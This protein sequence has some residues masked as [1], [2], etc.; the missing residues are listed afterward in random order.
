MSAI[1]APLGANDVHLFQ[2]RGGHM[3][4]FIECVR[5]RG[6]TAATVEIGHRSAT[7]CHLGNIA[8]T[9]ERKLRWDPKAEEFPGDAEA[10]RMRHRP[11]REPYTL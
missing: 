10:N 9:L 4:N 3:G 11:Y 8:M 6:R 2:P 5:T 7:V 1:T